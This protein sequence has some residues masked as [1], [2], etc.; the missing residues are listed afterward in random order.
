[1]TRARGGIKKTPWTPE[2]EKMRI[3]QFAGERKVYTDEELR[4]QINA[5]RMMKNKNPGN[6]KLRHFLNKEIL[7]LNKLLE[8]RKEKQKR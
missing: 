2:K 4:Q 8:E 5:R 7:C 6:E 1:M 3:M